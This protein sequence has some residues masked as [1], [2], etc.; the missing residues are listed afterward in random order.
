[1]E[2][3]SV[4][5]RKVW[6]LSTVSTRPRQDTPGRTQRHTAD[7]S[8]LL[9]TLAS[10]ALTNGLGRHRAIGYVVGSA[11]PNADAFF[12]HCYDLPAPPEAIGCLAPRVRD[13]TLGVPTDDVTSVLRELARLWD[14]VPGARLDLLWCPLS[15]A[16]VVMILKSTMV[17]WFDDACAAIV[18][19]T[20]AALPSPPLPDAAPAAAAATAAVP[21]AG[22]AGAAAAAAVRGL[23]SVPLSLPQARAVCEAQRRSPGQ[24]S[25]QG[26]LAEVVVDGYRPDRAVVETFFRKRCRSG[27]NKTL[28]LRGRWGPNGEIEVVGLRTRS[29]LGPHDF[30]A[31]AQRGASVEEPGPVR[32]VVEGPRAMYRLQ[33]PGTVA[34]F[35][36]DTVKR[37]SPSGTPREK[38]R[39]ID[40]VRVPYSGCP[41]QL[42]A[43]PLERVEAHD[44]AFAAAAQRLPA[45]T[46]TVTAAAAPTAAAAAAAAHAAEP[47]SSGP[48][49][50]P[51]S[52]TPPVASSTDPFFDWLWQPLLVDDELPDS[53]SAVAGPNVVDAPPDI[54]QQA[55]DE[56]AADGDK[57][58]ASDEWRRGPPDGGDVPATFDAATGLLVPGPGSEGRRRRQCDSDMELPG[59]KRIVMDWSVFIN[60]DDDDH[61]SAMHTA[62]RFMWS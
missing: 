17:Q 48:E 55:G 52:G 26:R 6:R 7:T 25:V 24:S 1:M 61:D 58:H 41:W 62:D 4:R 31:L 3:G 45:P 32:V 46:T 57:G 53:S 27:A 11:P 5:D 20:G 44:N 38:M 42:I 29:D 18:N 15:S 22:A 13:P 37:I 43:V 47:C 56:L 60:G 54:V 21:A 51:S 12:L 50:G 35:V 28:G 33:E 59:G 2:P 8:P 36:A 39:V 9:S 10:S 14:L 40:L 23:V 34:R 19:G 49:P 30:G 16:F